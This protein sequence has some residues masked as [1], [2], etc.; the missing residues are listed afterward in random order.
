M[1]FGAVFYLSFA[2]IVNGSAPFSE[3][4]EVFSYALRQENVSGIATIHHP[5]GHVDA[6]SGNIEVL[7]HIGNCADR[8]AVNAHS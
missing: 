7:I 5:L 3:L 4:R 2:E 8:P 1:D 6:A